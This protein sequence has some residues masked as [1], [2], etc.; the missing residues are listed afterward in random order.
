MV[1]AFAAAQL[2]DAVIAAQP[3]ERDP[4]LLLG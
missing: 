1:N 2:G 4:D 3:F